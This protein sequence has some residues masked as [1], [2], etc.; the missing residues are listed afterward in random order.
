MGR[1]GVDVHGRG[2]PE[3][4]MQCDAPRCGSARVT[5]DPGRGHR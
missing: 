4:R 5:V 1:V 2:E 3:L